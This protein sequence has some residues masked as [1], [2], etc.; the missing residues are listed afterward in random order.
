MIVQIQVLFK[1]IKITKTS[2][3]FQ[4]PEKIFFLKNV[5]IEF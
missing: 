1:K 3:I 5:F 4:I 2:N